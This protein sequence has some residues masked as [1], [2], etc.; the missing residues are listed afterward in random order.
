MSPLPRII[1]SMPDE[2]IYLTFDDG[3]DENITPR[4]L[5]LLSKHEIKA[6]FFAKKTEAAASEAINILIVPKLSAS[7]RYWTKKIK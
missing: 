5:E 6:T 2:N 1:R 3:P 4:L 7:N